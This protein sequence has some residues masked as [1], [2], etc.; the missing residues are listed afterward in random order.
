MLLLTVNIVG[1]NGEKKVFCTLLVSTYLYYYRG[2]LMAQNYQNDTKI[3]QNRGKNDRMSHF[4]IVTRNK[5]II[6]T[7]FV[8]SVV[9]VNKND[10]A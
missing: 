9:C 2:C 8:Y 4:K 6:G 5:N 10:K 3:D 1:L 7:H